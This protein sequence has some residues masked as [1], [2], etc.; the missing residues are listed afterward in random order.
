MKSLLVITKRAD[1]IFWQSLIYAATTICFTHY[2]LQRI[3][4]YETHENRQTLYFRHKIV[5][6]RHVYYVI[7]TVRYKIV[8]IL[9]SSVKTG[10]VLSTKHNRV[11]SP[12][13]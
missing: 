4:Y 7:Y 9:S 1:Y 2:S 3:L 12:P 11:N 6:Y 5:V 13:G 10:R 8:P